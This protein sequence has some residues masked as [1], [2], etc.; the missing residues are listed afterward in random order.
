MGFYKRNV[1]PWLCDRMTSGPEADRRRRQ[2]L[3]LARGRV[4]EIGFGTGLNAAHYPSEVVSVVG[5]D[6]NPGVEK[7][8]ETHCGGIGSDRAPDHVG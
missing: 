5:L 2:V 7:S 4:L 3:G 1:F 6:P 8:T